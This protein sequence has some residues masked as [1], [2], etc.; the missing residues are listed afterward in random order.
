MAAGL[1]LGRVAIVTGAG[2]GLGRVIAREYAQ[3]G[4]TVA[5]LDRNP[6]TLAE[7]SRLIEVDG[8]SARAY[9]LDVTD[10]ATYG[11]TVER[12]V[13]DAGGI[14]ILVNNA[15]IARYGT[16]LEDN[17]EDWRAQIAVNLEAVYMG[18]KLVAPHMIA[19]GGGR[20][21][22]ITSIQGFA[23]SGEAG[24]YNAAKGG[25]IAYTKSLAVE[26]APYG[27]AANAI[28]PGFMRT[29]MSFIDGVDET[30]TDDF[31][32]WY[33]ERRKVPMARTGLP[34]DVAGTAVFLASDYCRY[35]TGQTLVVDGGLTSTF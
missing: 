16:I 7:T 23:A 1:L 27:I 35:M 18:S 4:A 33:V 31:K 12:V 11:E 10:H 13:A 28:A 21:I 8:G 20:I 19:R 9:V 17:L 32:A 25:I 2:Q 26:L 30:T 5:L 3:E 29:P 15:A 14:D 6:E 24:A 22:S 34:E